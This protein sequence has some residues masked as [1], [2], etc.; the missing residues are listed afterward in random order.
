MAQFRSSARE[1]SFSD[2]QLK[3]PSTTDKIQRE[4]QRQLSGMD[5]AQAFQKENQRIFLQ[6]QKQTQSIQENFRKAARSVSKDSN[7]AE[8]KFTKQAYERE[9]LKKQNEDKYAIDTF[10]ALKDFSK[11]AFDIT[12]GII[13]QNQEIQQ[14]A[15]NEI[16]SRFQLSQKDALAA[17]SVDSSISSQQWQETEV[18]QDYLKQGKSQE[19]INTMYDHLVKGGGYRN[20]IN[21]SIVLDETGRAHAKVALEAVQKDIEDGLPADQIE[22]RLNATFAKFRAG[23]T[24]DGEKPSTLIQRK[25]YNKHLDKTRDRAATLI[26]KVKTDTLTLETNIKR[27]NTVKDAF[28]TGGVASAMGLLKTKSSAGAVDE[29]VDILI[30]QNLTADQLETI[31]KNPIEIN[32]QIATLEAFPEAYAAVE[33]A[34][35]DLR[36]ETLQQIA[37]EKEVQQAEVDL[38]GEELY[39]EK[40]A[41]EVFT[42][43]EYQETIA[44]KDNMYPN[45]DRS[46]DKLLKARTIDQVTRA[47]AKEQL[48]GYLRD[49]TLS[50][51]LMDEMLLP[52]ELD[53]QYRNDARRLDEIRRTGEFKGARKYFRD[54]VIGVIGQ[55]DKLVLIDGGKQSDQ[56][57]WYANA[58]VNRAV[59][60]YQA[61]V[62]AGVE[63]PLEVVGNNLAV[64][65]DTELK[66]PGFVKDFNIIPY[67]ET[68]REGAPE[69]LKAQKMVTR[70]AGKTIKEKSNPNTWVEIV[71]T[72]GLQSASKELAEKGNSEVL[73]ILGSN[74]HP[75]LTPYEVQEKIAEVNPD[76]EPV[77]VPTYMELYKALPASIKNVLAGNTATYEAKLRA[78]KEALQ[79]YGQQTGQ[80]PVRSTFSQAAVP[81]EGSVQEKGRQAIT[82]MTQDLGMSENHAYGLLANAIRESSLQTTNPGDNGTSDGWFQWHKD[83][84]SRAKA[85]LGDQWNNWQA[86]IQ[87][88]LQEEG[89]PGQE[90][91]NQTFSSRQEAADWWMKYFERPAHP[92]RDSKRM[93]EILGNF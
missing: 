9:L 67:Q 21:N 56:V 12:S 73:R 93:R 60:D 32:G 8:A 79:I 82:Y 80:P 88:A 10:G 24:I 25:G 85:A 66:K 26:N 38:A 46:Q 87:Y 81:L 16:S 27:T 92:E 39:K 17:K 62:M 72:K 7:E 68:M 3:A 29:V 33:K 15:I 13:K 42:D 47:A 22:A 70:L 11:T 2:N 48:D 61:A 18:V 23:L 86:Q 75:P 31:K 71:G 59:K 44:F 84:L 52:K 43:V 30:K 20:Y 77:E 64:K 6:A 74:S 49:K 34:E 78:A 50:E 37:L 53:N 76:I 51:S 54:R 65:V 91:L 14:Q 5:R 90:Y 35:N 45:R 28:N 69:A 4:A 58:K 40:F 89:E 63:N 55:T 19:F 41:D 36:Q 83:R 57:E 1:G